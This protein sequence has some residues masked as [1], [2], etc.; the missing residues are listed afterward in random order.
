MEYNIEKTKL[1]H[2]SITQNGT[3]IQTLYKTEAEEY[4][5]HKINAG[6]SL[7]ESFDKQKAFAWLMHS[8]SKKVTYKCTNRNK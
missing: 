4:F 3:L 1:V 6:I 2:Q 8:C 5:L 7:F